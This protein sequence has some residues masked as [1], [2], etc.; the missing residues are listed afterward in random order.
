V[1][2]QVRSIEQLV[3]RGADA[4]TNFVANLG[5]VLRH[6]QNRVVLLHRQAL[7]GD[8]LFYGINGLIQ[9]LLLA[10]A[11]AAIRW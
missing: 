8:G 3:G 4:L 6:F 10:G 11:A 9:E 5:I 7:I 2:C 1:A